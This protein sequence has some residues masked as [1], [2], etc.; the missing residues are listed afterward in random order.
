MTHRHTLPID[1]QNPWTDGGRDNNI[2]D[3]PSQNPEHTPWAW[4]DDSILWIN[5]D[6]VSET[7]LLE[8]IAALAG[9][10]GSVPTRDDVVAHT[11]FHPA[12]YVRRFGSFTAALEKA[13]VLDGYRD[14]VLDE[15]VLDELHGLADELG[16]SPTPNDI[17]DEFVVD[18]EEILTRFGRWNNALYEASVEVVAGSELSED[19]QYLLYTEEA[20][21]F[22]DGFGEFGYL[23]GWDEHHAVLE[24]LVEQ[25]EQQFS[26]SEFATG[27]GIS[28][29]RAQEMLEFVDSLGRVRRDDTGW[30]V[31]VDEQGEVA[32]WLR[33]G[34]TPGV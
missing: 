3:I 11:A 13:H 24:F 27:V 30:A 14:G 19:E 21:D 6:E 7:E 26:T 9:Q 28:E 31:R 25:G 4:N 22:Q 10:D 32:G 17:D 23:T 18:V 29:E 1:T 15:E 16:R 20:G 5:D 12:V 2:E 33:R 34:K 8:P